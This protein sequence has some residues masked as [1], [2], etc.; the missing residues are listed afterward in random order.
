MS[1]ASKISSTNRDILLL[2]HELVSGYNISSVTIGTRI[3][4]ARRVSSANLKVFVLSNS[5]FK[6]YS[7]FPEIPFA[8]RTF[9]SNIVSL[10]NEAYVSVWFTGYDGFKYL[11]IFVTIVDD[12][13]NQ[14]KC[15]SKRRTIFCATPESIS[16]MVA[17]NDCIYVF[18]SDLGR[19][20][21]IQDKWDEI[22]PLPTL[23]SYYQSVVCDNLV[24]IIGGVGNTSPRGWLTSIDVFDIATHKWITTDKPP[25]M[26]QKRISHTAVTVNERYIAVIGG[27][28]EEHDI[29]VKSQIFDTLTNLWHICE[30]NTSTERLFCGATVTNKHDPQLILFGGKSRK[31]ENLRSTDS[32]SFYRLQPDLL[33]SWRPD[34][35]QY[36]SDQSKI[37][38]MIM[39][40]VTQRGHLPIPNEILIDHI[41]PYV[42]S[43]RYYR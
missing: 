8:S 7:S 25:P 21:T 41:F 2:P 5:T 43:P 15:I 13:R 36:Y 37:T 39:L 6:E 30:V 40:Q 34:L 32:V 17:A 42:C 16:R 38:V 19:Y 9:F 22:P 3:V 31:G 27:L 23:R 18:S 12:Q 29:A 20:N 26:P 11:W 28:N 33:P 35:H 14:W 10:R 24:Y 1:Y 4:L